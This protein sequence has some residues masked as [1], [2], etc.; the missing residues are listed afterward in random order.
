MHR[1]RL[2]GLVL[3]AST[4]S[5]YEPLALLPSRA[6]HAPRAGRLV[7]CSA[8][9]ERNGHDTKNLQ[10]PTSGMQ[11]QQQRA[12]V[13]TL[14]A[15]QQHAGILLDAL[16]SWLRSQTI[17]SVLPREQAKMLIADLRDDRRFWAQ[18]RRQF[19]SLFVTIEQSLRA[20]ERPMA[21]VLGPG[22]SERLLKAIEEMDDDPKLVNAVLR[23]EVVERLIGHVLYEGIFE[24]VEGADL[25]GNVFGQL[26]VLGAIRMQML[27]A[28]RQQLDALL[29]EQI[30][31][32]LG[33]Y[34]ASAAESAAGYLLSEDLAGARSKARRAAAQK[35]LSK[36][37]G[38]LVAL[39]DL[40][41][42]LVRDA[43]WSAVQ[44]FRLPHE[45][46]L[47][48]RL[49]LE[50]GEQP[51][52]ILLPSNSA[53]AR[54]DAPLFERGRSVLQDIVGRFF[55]SNEWKS[56]SRSEEGTELLTRSASAPLDEPQ[57]A[58][59]TPQPP[60]AQPPPPQQW[61]GWD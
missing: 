48:D 45:A 59:S 54:G 21:E 36:P 2:A 8:P 56:W 38:E 5:A 39:G 28:A 19:S 18:Q 44:E 26:P 49:Y 1:L 34:T 6:P 57:I 25:L 20:E 50:F 9:L 37:I 29:G 22:T 32:F 17:E 3:L 31:R 16:D 42:A 12:G 10:P 58:T 35:V 40:E 23:S 53:A 11:Q 60:P 52:D 61:D 7:A 13:V 51:F 41:M 33:E 15:E 47:V 30:T 46:E 43:V 27:K 14:D 55:L 24:F 4:T